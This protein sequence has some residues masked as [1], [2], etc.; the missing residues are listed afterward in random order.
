MCAT[1][2]GTASTVTRGPVG[3]RLPTGRARGP[4][5]HSDRHDNAREGTPVDLALVIALAAAVLGGWAS[6]A[7][8][9]VASSVPVEAGGFGHL[10]TRIARSPLWLAALVATG[11]GFLLHAWAL[12]LGN[13]LAV[14]PVASTALLFALAIGSW[15]AHER[16]PAGVWVP[17][18]F[19]VAGLAAFLVAGDPTGGDTDAPLL[20]WVVA[21]LIIL[22]LV[23]VLSLYAFRG[24]GAR[25]ALAL[26]FVSGILFGVVASLT[27]AVT[28]DFGSGLAADLANWKLWLMLGSGAAAFLLQ[29]AAFQSGSIALVLPAASVMP[30]ITAAAVA[31]LVLDSDLDLSGLRPVWIAL[32]VVAMIGGLIAIARVEARRM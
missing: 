18:I 25:R 7:Q 9:R 4:T 19:L 26:G 6:V 31:I 12:G 1:T 5:R 22:A 2:R 14:E 13:L 27:K 24:R 8:Q 21:L 23:V 20:R 3:S 30:P 16:L 10:I 11:A 17:A 32:A 15:W 28:L 29:Q